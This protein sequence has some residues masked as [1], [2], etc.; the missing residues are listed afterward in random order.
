MRIVAKI[1]GG[2]PKQLEGDVMRMKENSKDISQSSI[3]KRNAKPHPVR[4][5]SQGDHK[6]AA[7]LVKMVLLSS[8][9]IHC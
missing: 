2:H 7:S 3:E 9:F 5:S 4:K 1:E 8:C 6:Q